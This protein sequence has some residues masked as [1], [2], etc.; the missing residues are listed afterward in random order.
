MIQMERARGL[1]NV[2]QPNLQSVPSSESSCTQTPA[3]MNLAASLVE[4]VF[5]GM[6]R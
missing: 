1:S 5:D 2:T 4:Y 3:P 6:L